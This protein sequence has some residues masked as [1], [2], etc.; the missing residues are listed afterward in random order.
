MNIGDG[1]GAPAMVG[2]G[3]S[4]MGG[5]HLGV[6]GEFNHAP[7]RDFG[8]STSQVKVSPKMLMPGVVVRI[9]IPVAGGMLR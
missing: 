1:G 3:A 8:A 2:G 7:I 5:T 9:Y 6:F 4:V